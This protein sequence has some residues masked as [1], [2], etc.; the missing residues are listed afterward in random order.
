M[1]HRRFLAAAVTAALGATLIAP[2]AANAGTTPAVS[3]SDC[4]DGFQ[5]ATVAAP[6]DY[7]HPRGTQIALSLLRLPATDPAHRIGS[8]LVNPGGPGGPGVDFVREA[9]AY[10]PAEVRAR[11]DIVGFDPRGIYRSTP[12]LCFDSSDDAM[13]VLPAAPYP[14]TRAEEQKQ[15]YWSSVTT[16]T[17]PPATRAP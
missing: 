12:L 2:T 16:S 6:L 7:D 13:A 17:R 9:G 11:F 3:W 10:F 1:A 14:E 15:R 5:C 8:L 4:Q